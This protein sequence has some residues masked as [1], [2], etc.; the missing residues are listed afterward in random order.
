[1]MGNKFELLA[2]W[3]Y[4]SRGAVYVILGALAV[5][6]ASPGEEGQEGALSALLGQ[7][8]GRVL[9][10]AV[11]L[12]LVGHV[13]WRFAQG[14]LDADHHGTGLKA[15]M[16]R[17]GSIVSGVANAVLAF[18]AARLVFASG[19]GSSGGGEDSVAAW[20]M[21]QPFGRV[22]AAAVGLALVAGG[23]VQVWRGVSGQYRERVKLPSQY[24]A[25]LNA[26]SVFGLAAR[27]V[28]LAITGG[29]FVYAA[30]TV[31]P[32]QAGSMTEAL[33]WVRGLPFGSVL[34]LLAAVGLIAFGLYSFIQGRYRQVDAPDVSDV[35]HA[36]STATAR[37]QS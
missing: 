30:I 11:T 31:D 26:L 29:F 17:G 1:M 15:L 28:L 3:G 21:Q 10:A 22:L 4:A 12:G 14:L 2:R 16:A 7:P 23:A 6:G 33:D 35:A 9:L 20:L 27:G 13:L 18:T 37:L 5:T 32:E 19:G 36:A 24:D 34:Y 8:F 25:V